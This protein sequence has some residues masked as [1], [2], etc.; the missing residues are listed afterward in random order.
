MGQQVSPALPSE[1]S[2][3][4]VCYRP[5]LRT[6]VRFMLQ[7]ATQNRDF[8]ILQC[9]QWS[10]SMASAHCKHSGPSSR[11]RNC[12]LGVQFQQRTPR[13]TTSMVLM[14]TP[15]P[16]PHPPA[17]HQ[18]QPWGCPLVG[19]LNRYRRLLREKELSW[20][21]GWLWG[22]AGSSPSHVHVKPMSSLIWQLSAGLAFHV[23]AC[24]CSQRQMCKS[25]NSVDSTSVC[26]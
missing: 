8:A 12:G 13:A 19:P 22:R 4:L 10:P 14:N 11:L 15:T 26:C 21:K 23:H 25:Q 20:S 16:T 18:Q 5:S 7:P 2:C 3:L 1:S 24:K 17:S 9:L 6:Q